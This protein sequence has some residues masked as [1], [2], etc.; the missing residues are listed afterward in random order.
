[1][2]NKHPLFWKIIML[3]AAVQ[4]LIGFGEHFLQADGQSNR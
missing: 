2:G 3:V 4:R 1:M